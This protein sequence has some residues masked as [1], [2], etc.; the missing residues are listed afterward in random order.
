MA[1]FE[2]SGCSTHS[3]LEIRKADL[4]DW[5]EWVTGAEVRRG[6][7]ACTTRLCRAQ[8]N[9][10]LARTRRHQCVAASLCA[11]H[12]PSANDGTRIE[13]HGSSFAI[14]RSMRRSGTSQISATST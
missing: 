3:I 14:A 10:G 11:H 4:H 8:H 6:Y 12:G 13:S 1:E 9:I 7:H 5:Q 2:A